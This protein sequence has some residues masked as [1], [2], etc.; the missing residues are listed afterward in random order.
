MQSQTT[1]VSCQKWEKTSPSVEPTS[2]A[3]NCMS[4][5]EEKAA[6]RNKGIWEQ[7]GSM[8][9][10]AGGVNVRAVM[11]AVRVCMNAWPGVSQVRSL[12]SARARWLRR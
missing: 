7:M 9:P 4:V 3:Y 1:P 6:Q 8:V 12:V 10:I 11:V 5:A 2:N